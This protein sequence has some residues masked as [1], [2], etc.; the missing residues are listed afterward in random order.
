MYEIGLHEAMH[1]LYAAEHTQSGIMCVEDGPKKNVSRG[2][3]AVGSYI[4][5]P[6]FWPLRLHPTQEAVYT[7]YG[8]PLLHG[9]HEQGDRRTAHRR[10]LGDA[11]MVD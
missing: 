7:L 9:W 11:G 2:C 6:W 1:A 8:N 5:Q 4:A 10:E 3:G